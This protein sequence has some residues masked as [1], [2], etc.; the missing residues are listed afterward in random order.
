MLLGV[1]PLFSQKETIIVRNLES[2][3]S[4]FNDFHAIPVGEKLIVTTARD[5]NGMVCE[6][7]E[8]KGERYA[9]LYVADKSTAK[10]YDNLRQIGGDLEIKYHDAVP[11]VHPNQKVMIFTRSYVPDPDLKVLQLFSA[12]KVNGK[13]TEVKSLPFNTTEYSNIHPT[14]SPDG[15]K[16]YFASNRPPGDLQKDYN[17]WEVDYNEGNWGEPRLLQGE[18]NSKGTDYFPFADEEGRL[19]FASNG[20]KGYG[21][22]DIFMSVLTNVGWSL[23][24]ALPKPINSR[25]DDFS[26]VANEDGKSG[27]LG[28]NRNGGKGDD[29]IWVW[30]N[31][32]RPLE[33][34]LIVTNAET[35]VQ[36]E[37]ADILIEPILEKIPNTVFIDQENLTPKEV[38]SKKKKPIDYTIV[39]NGYYRVTV[40]KPGYEPLILPDLTAEELESE[41]VYTLPLVPIKRFIDVEGSVLNVQ[42]LDPIP[43][44][45]VLV[46]NLCTKK[47]TEYMTDAEGKF[48]F[49]ANCACDYD[50]HA[51]KAKF[52]D[53]Y[54][55][56]DSSNYD[57]DN[58]PS[59]SVTLKLA[60]PVAKGLVIV[61]EDV[62]Y[63]FDKANIRPDA[64]FELD[65]VVRLMERYPSMQI[66]LGS[67]TDS[68][69]NDD[70]NMDLSQR[71]ADSAIEYIISRGISRKRIT[72]RGYGESKI[73]NRCANGVKCSEEE[74]QV[75]RRTEITIT[76]LD[77]ENVEIGGQ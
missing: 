67:H 55:S 15:K 63:D 24:E 4:E 29:D 54:L 70:Y 33:V 48:M 39:P 25:F 1:A 69:G 7:P 52:V 28:S 30:T 37:D 66:E 46:K 6:D 59:E 22:T 32:M 36:L 58:R 38:M 72:A 76:E 65:K 56:M 45:K 40:T 35:D 75:N 51:S 73:V 9:D 16:I 49:Q 31:E 19:F 41:E 21:G 68:R 13:W 62:Y 11:T 8:L 77:E 23:P 47:V 42:S 64:A 61:V 5:K 57:C 43:N 34:K 12:R 44:S 74:H 60:P 20:H 50:L 10:G 2:V 26:Y 14:F 27:F 17:L 71:R 3:N 53:D 18:I